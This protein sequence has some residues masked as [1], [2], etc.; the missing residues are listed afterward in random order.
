MFYLLS[1]LFILAIP[2][3]CI[4]GIIVLIDLFDYLKKFHRA[5]WNELCFERIFG[6]EQ[7]DFFFYPVNPKKL[8]AFLF[9]AD[10]LNDPN[11]ASYKKR[12]K[13]ILAIF[14]ALCV[15][16]FLYMFL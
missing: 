15:L 16:F 5:K 7:E 11:L 10:N 6:I 14:I 9:S 3:S 2:A 13:L 4:W 12:L 8:V 1:F